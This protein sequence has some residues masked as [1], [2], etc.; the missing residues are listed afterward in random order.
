MRVHE[1]GA[2]AVLWTASCAGAG[3]EAVRVNA[4]ADA[5]APEPFARIEGRVTADGRVAAA[6][7]DVRRLGDPP[8]EREW[9]SLRRARLDVPDVASE[10]SASSDGAVEFAGLAPGW[11]RLTATGDGGRG[12]VA[13]VEVA[14]PG[15]RVVADLRLFAPA[16]DRVS[17]GTVLGLPS[18]AV[19]YVFAAPLAVRYD[20]PRR[21]VPAALVAA[22]GTFVLAGLG[23]GT[24]EPTV[25]VPRRLLVRT[26]PVD[27]APEESI[28][29]DVAATVRVVTVRVVAAA[30]G[31]PVSAATV[32][33]SDERGPELQAE[34]MTGADGVVR[35]EAPRGEAKLSVEAGGYPIASVTVDAARDDVPVRL[36]RGPAVTARV[37]TGDGDPVPR[38]TVWWTMLSSFRG[39]GPVVT[40]AQGRARLAGMS[41]G[42][43]HVFVADPAWVSAGLEPVEKSGLWGLGDG[44]QSLG[45]SSSRPP[46]EGLFD[47]AS[48]GEVVLDIEVEPAREVGGRVVDEHGAPVSGALVV[49]PTPEWFPWPQVWTAPWAATAT[50]ET[51]AFVLRGVFPRGE[52]VIRASTQGHACVEVPVPAADEAASL[53]LVASESPL[54]V[55]R[56]RGTGAPVA[57]AYVD[58]RIDKIPEGVHIER[59]RWFTAD[60]GAVRIGPLPLARWT[61]DVES[62]SHVESRPEALEPEQLSSG[63]PVVIEL[64][65]G[66]A[67]TGRVLLPDGRPA[68]G[69]F[70]YIAPV[71][72]R[73]RSGYDVAL[74]GTFIRRGVAAGRY[75]V[76]AHVEDGARRYEGSIVVDAG[77]PPAELRLSKVDE[78]PARAMAR[79]V[80]FDGEPVA[81]GSYWI[82]SPRFGT[83]SGFSGGVIDLGQI[84]EEG[85]GT[86]EVYDVEDA[87]GQ[88]CG[89]GATSVKL[90]HPVPPDFVVRLER[91]RPIRGRVTD[92]EGRPVAGARLTARTA[93]A[94]DDDTGRFG[95][96]TGRAHG[97]AVSAADGIFEIRGAGDFAYALETAPPEA[98]VA[99]DE[100]RTRGGASDVAIV[101]KTGLR[102][103]VVVL[104][105]EGSPVVGASVSV[106]SLQGLD[107]VAEATTGDD[108]A[109]TL[110]S[111]REGRKFRL[112]VSPPHDVA[113]LSKSESWTSRSETT[114]RLGRRFSAAGTIIDP[115]GRPVPHA[116]YWVFRGG[117]FGPHRDSADEHGR[118]RVDGVAEGDVLIAAGDFP[119]HQMS[120][121][122]W[123]SLD[124]PELVASL[125][126]RI[127]AGTQD[128]RVPL[129][130]DRLL[131]IDLEGPA[132]VGATDATTTLFGST[133]KTRWEDETHRPIVTDD[134]R[135]LLFTGVT[136]GRAFRLFAR[137][138][139]RG[140]VVWEEHLRT[141][142][143]RTVKWR[144]GK[145][146]V[147]KV[148][149][150]DR[151]EHH[152]VEVRVEIGRL[153]IPTKTAR[154][155]S[156]RIGALPPVEV[157]VRVFA[158]EADGNWCDD[159]RATPG[160]PPVELR[161]G[162]KPIP[163]TPR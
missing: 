39:G 66:L 20:G 125:A 85:G 74:D 108:G 59:W 36:R 26:A 58:L 110:P 160:A 48:S 106:E 150:P 70:V 98:F 159:F 16:G 90:P 25:V 42:R 87:T 129:A 149:L 120:S 34:A 50:D 11:Y 97:A 152:N 119:W 155:G 5:A 14:A 126:T 141:G 109:A 9:E 31:A 43:A 147:G 104:G 13:D 91:E 51:G 23:P 2:L 143:R 114:I 57:G 93:S 111:L 133:G 89:A 95:P 156:F 62:P 124:E 24:F 64:D 99:P 101:V 40:D 113:L 118:F 32:R 146:L 72:A 121:P 96:K 151:T 86:L 10:A 145:D 102:A 128:A 117:Q 162:D 22:D 130:A 55:V 49:A 17:R 33:C 103:R 132:G 157:D 163:A 37:V 84:G 75:E 30:D 135:T 28:E 6:R 134:G 45:S 115:D 60:D 8:G 69:G 19:A 76:E 123:P 105:P 21:P 78:K 71:G 52:Q 136:P 140:L 161:P 15:Q 3:G 54:V 73:S 139:T 27:P 18:A 158:S 61:I 153:W 41:P 53:R 68:Q 107:T 82:G 44:M 46:R 29:V 100:T 80:D 88:P 67:V 92:A 63:D 7:V 38:A 47:V 116:D 131:R 4:Q 65:P 122:G 94:E 138:E 127:P 142:G 77:G 112:H 137:S 154:D 56:E 148:V 12:C 79:V 83:G 81:R 144:E 35:I 1:L